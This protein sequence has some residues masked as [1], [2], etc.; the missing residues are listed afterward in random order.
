[1]WNDGGREGGCGRGGTNRKD[2]SVK[3]EQDDGNGGNEMD[4]MSEIVWWRW[5]YK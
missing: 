1:M 3:W 2:D 4:V 5:Y